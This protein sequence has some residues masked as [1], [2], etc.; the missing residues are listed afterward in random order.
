VAALAV[1]AGL[2]IAALSKKSKADEPDQ[3]INNYCS[4]GG[5]D[6]AESA[7][8]LANIGQW[9]GIGGVV[10]TAVGVTLI[11]TAPKPRANARL[12]RKNLAIAPW[13]GPST[14]GLFVSGAL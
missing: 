14:G 4:P 6:Q 12:P 7:K 10:V 5:I 1:A 2:E 11:L 9:V 8:N 3:C 13:L